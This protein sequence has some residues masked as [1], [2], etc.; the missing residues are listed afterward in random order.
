MLKVAGAV[1]TLTIVATVPA[2]AH[3]PASSLGTVQITHAVQ[4]GGTTL[5]PGTYE[6][7]LTGEHV[8]PMPGQSEDAEQRIEIVANGQVVARDAA[9]VIPVSETAVGTSSGRTFGR[10]QM[11]KGGEFLRVSFNR[12]SERFLVHLPMAR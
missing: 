6:I 1:L 10:V 12:G 8:K 7:R 2:L 3:H 9:T 11:L 4:A 5:Q